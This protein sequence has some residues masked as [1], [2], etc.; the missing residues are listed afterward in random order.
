MTTGFAA[1]T[2]AN[3]ILDHIRGGTAFTQPA[4]LFIKLHLG[5]PGAA[6]TS[7]PAALTTRQAVSFAAAAAGAMALSNSPAFTASAAETWS[8]F[9]VWDHVSAGNFLFSGALGTSRLVAIGDIGTFTSLPVSFT[10]I[11]A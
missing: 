2:L 11:A 7:N 5:D 1:T 8:H 6:G 4:G 9:S 3:K 10:P